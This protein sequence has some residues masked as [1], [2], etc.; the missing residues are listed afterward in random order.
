MPVFL[1]LWVD[2][3]NVVGMPMPAGVDIFFKPEICVLQIIISPVTFARELIWGKAPSRRYHISDEDLLVLITLKPTVLVLLVHALKSISLYHVRHLIALP[4]S[5]PLAGRRSATPRRRE[6]D[7]SIGAARLVRLA[8]MCL[9]SEGTR[10][11]ISMAHGR[12]GS[13]ALRGG[14]A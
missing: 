5:R 3:R 11:M 8:G 6:S 9:S 2:L 4:F 12:V 10:R 13:L 1:R 7:R 14:R